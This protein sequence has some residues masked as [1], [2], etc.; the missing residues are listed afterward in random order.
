MEIFGEYSSVGRQRKKG[1]KKTEA[2]L[3]RRCKDD[4]EERGGNGA[5]DPCSESHPKRK[6]KDQDHRA[7][8]NNPK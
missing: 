7:S 8:S 1:R 6:L 2:E 3:T 5:R 4:D